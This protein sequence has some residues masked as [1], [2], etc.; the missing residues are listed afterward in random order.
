M[1]SHKLSGWRWWGR[2]V[3]SH[4][5]SLWPQLRKKGQSLRN[6]SFAELQ[7]LRI[8]SVSITCGNLPVERGRAMMMLTSP[9]GQDS[10]WAH[11][12]LPGHRMGVNRIIQCCLAWLVGCSG[13]PKISSSHVCASVGR[14]RGGIQQHCHDCGHG[15]SSTPRHG[16][17][18]ASVRT[19]VV[20]KETK[21]SEQR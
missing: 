15:L 17:E 3:P 6:H 7:I 20:P 9:V 13:G 11:L 1:G 8:A 12:A 5:P 18:A 14:A 16:E 19:R 2:H 21:V 4:F 10:R